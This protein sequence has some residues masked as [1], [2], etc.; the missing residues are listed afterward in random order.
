MVTC[1]YYPDQ[2]GSFRLLEQLPPDQHAADFAGAGTDFVEFCV[3]QDAPGWEVVDIAVAA[4]ALDRLERHPGRLL[5]REQDSPRRVLAR[6]LAA[7][8][9]AR[10]R[11]DV[12]LRSIHGHVHVG[13]L[14]LHDLE[15]ADRRAEL[16]AL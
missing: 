3:A 8:A 10:D 2:S 6:G 11:I 12:S 15:A 14:R 13:E 9:S 7:I 1:Q 4:Q 16:L 5:G